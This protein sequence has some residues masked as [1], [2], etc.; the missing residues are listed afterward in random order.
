MTPLRYTLRPDGPTEARLLPV[1]NWLL[2]QHLPDVEI[3]PQFADPRQLP[4]G[5]PK[6]LGEKIR[7][8]LRLFPC[9]LLFVHRDAEKEDPTNRVEEIA[10][11]VALVDGSPRH[12]PVVP[13]RMSEA[14]LLFDESAIRRAAGNPNGRVKLKLPA[15][16][17]L[18][19]ETDPK[20]TLKELLL[21]A[22]GL[23]GRRLKSFA[24]Q[25]AMYQLAEEIEDY[26][27]LRLLPAF[28]RLETDVAEF[29]AEWA[30]TAVEK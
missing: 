4:Q 5:S 3:R 28:Q 18:E 16:K 13:V 21:E 22:S 24:H 20:E 1:L 14:W 27:P 9:D 6:D 7:L 29:A 8:S 19:R 23:N 10:G 2:G 26:S 25:R 15:V 12:I 11:A 30:H 17:N